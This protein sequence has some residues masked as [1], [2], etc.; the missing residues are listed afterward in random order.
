MEIYFSC[1]LT[2][3][4]KDAPV[5]QTIVDFLIAQG[6]RVP[7]QHL[8]H[9]DIMDRENI[10]D[11]YEVFQR[12][13]SWLNC[14]DGVVAE[15]STPSHGVGYEIAYALGLNKPVLCCFQSDRTVSKMITGN[16]SP[17]LMLTPYLTVDDLLPQ[18]AAFVE[19]INQ[20]AKR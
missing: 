7:T 15:V 12:D 3:G 8:A 10:V 18:L 16:T 2:G 19:N 6:I 1:S 20:P 4:R 9:P 13:I 17:G 14:C 11:P 5:Y